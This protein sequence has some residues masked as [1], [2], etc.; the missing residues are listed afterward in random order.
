[1]SQAR[2]DEAHRQIVE[3]TGL[4]DGDVAEGPID[5]SD[6]GYVSVILFDEIEKAHPIL[7]NALLGILEDGMLALGD[8]STTDFTRSIILMTSN[9]GSQAMGEFLERRPVG[10]AADSVPEQ[11]EATVR[12]LAL[13]AAREMF[14]LEFLNRFDEVLVYGALEHKH[15]EQVFEKFLA[16]LHQRALTQAGLPL[17]IKISD[18]AKGF[19]IDSGTDPRF[20]ARPLRRAVERYLVDPLSQLIAAGALEPGDVLQVDEESGR[21]EFFRQ[22]L[23]SRELVA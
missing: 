3:E 6:G 5:L 7:W 17:L 10:F 14:P 2:L 11:A 15:L 13:G 21:L 20:G 8:N 19:V 9:V 16:D 12:E 23:S 1:M 4:E 18:S 22:K